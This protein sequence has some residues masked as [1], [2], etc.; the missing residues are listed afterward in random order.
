MEPSP[1][2][3]AS[4]SKYQGVIATWLLAIASLGLLFFGGWQTFVVV[5]SEPGGDLRNRVAVARRM[6]AGIDPYLGPEAQLPHRQF[7]SY[8]MFL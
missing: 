6:L 4:V 2:N 1:R 8:S 7:S 3:D 5:R